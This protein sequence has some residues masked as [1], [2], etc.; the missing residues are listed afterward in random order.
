MRWGK[1]EIEGSI[2][3]FLAFFAMITTMLVFAA[4]TD[5]EKEK[6]K[7]LEI[8]KDI[9]YIQQTKGDNNV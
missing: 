6:T 1:F 9:E 2:I 3:I 8:Q 4:K 7:Q 5:L